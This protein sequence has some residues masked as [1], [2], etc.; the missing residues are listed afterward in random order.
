MKNE[1]GVL[2]RGEFP[3]NW[4]KQVKENQTN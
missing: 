3:T 1:N 4:P 2:G